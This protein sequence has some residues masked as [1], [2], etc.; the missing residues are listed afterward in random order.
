[1]MAS[2]NFDLTYFASREDAER[3]YLDYHV[4]LARRLPG[5]RS[6]V[7]G[8]PTDFAGVTATRQRAAV[9]IFD[10]REALRAAYRSD[11]GRELRQ[12]EQRLIADAVTTFMDAEDV[13]TTR[14]PS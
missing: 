4:P 9:L 3:H 6:Y 5:L 14:S 8:R 7:I 10:D 11:V 1:M 2:F 12:D 13:L